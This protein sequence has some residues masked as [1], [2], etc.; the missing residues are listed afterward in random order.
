[1]RIERFKYRSN[2]VKKKIILIIR[3]FKESNPRQIYTLI[4][5]IIL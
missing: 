3:T 5:F 4:V 2:L 1:M